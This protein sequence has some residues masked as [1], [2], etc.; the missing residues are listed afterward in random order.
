MAQWCTAFAY[1]ISRVEPSYCNKCICVLSSISTSDPGARIPFSFTVLQD[2]RIWGRYTGLPLPA[3]FHLLLT[4]A[5][6][7][8]GGVQEGRAGAGAGAVAGTGV[9]V[10]A[11]AGSG[12][13]VCAGMGANAG[14]DAAAGANT[15]G[16]NKRNREGESISSPQL[17]ARLCLHRGENTRSMLCEMVLPAVN[18]WSLLQTMA[19]RLALLHRC[20]R[21]ASRDLLP[22]AGG[23]GRGFYGSSVIPRTCPSRGMTGIQ[24]FFTE[25]AFFF[26]PSSP[27]PT[28]RA[29]LQ[30]TN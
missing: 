22:D 14:G 6:Q 2:E 10:R 19:L 23:R 29:P 21:A 4:R 3:S 20:S 8:A 12:T 27:T 25:P 5:M 30:R 15:G 24:D 7:S 11:G 9:D 13:E 26:F 17:N 18:G 16:D 28:C 1:D